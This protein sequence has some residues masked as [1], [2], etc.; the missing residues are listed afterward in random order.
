M[1]KITYIE[2]S[3]KSHNIKVF[4]GFSVKEGAVQKDIPGIDA[5]GGGGKACALSFMM[6]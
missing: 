1:P 5:E 6:N 4:N 3:G 2:D